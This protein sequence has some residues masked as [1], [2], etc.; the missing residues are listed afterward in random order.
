ME[1][2]SSW[3]DGDDGTDGDAIAQ[4]LTHQLARN[5]L[6]LLGI[7]KIF[8]DRDKDR[9]RKRERKRKRKYCQCFMRPISIEISV[10]SLSCIHVGTS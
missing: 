5:R 8:K 6:R 3:F 7:K 1:F 2:A 9:E 10:I 4:Q